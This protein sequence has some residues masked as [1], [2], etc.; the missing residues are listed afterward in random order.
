MTMLFQGIERTAEISPCGQ[1]RY[2]L[3]RQWDDGRHV[4]FLMFN[5][6]TADAE[7]EDHTIRKCIGFGKQ[8]GYGRMTV[9]NLFAL[10]ST[11]PKAVGRAV[12]P[13]GPLND[14]WIAETLRE[15]RELVC[16]WGCEDHMRSPRCRDRAANVLSTARSYGAPLEIRCL[17]R[18]KGGT[19]R[20]PLMLAYGTLRESF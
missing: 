5:P 6:S 4:T 15:T 18:T 19:P 20:H 3:G 12:D 17:G 14:Y 9:I 10:R 1:Y 13:I 7:T 8:W 2:T 16:A 11:D